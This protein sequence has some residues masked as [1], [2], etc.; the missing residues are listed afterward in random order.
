MAGHC[1]VDNDKQFDG[2]G[3]TRV[4]NLRQQDAQERAKL[5]ADNKL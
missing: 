5:E 3:Q 1:P 2:D 4:L